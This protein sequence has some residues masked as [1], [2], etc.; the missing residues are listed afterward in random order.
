[1]R[2]SLTFGCFSLN[3]KNLQDISTL[4]EHIEWRKDGRKKERKKQINRN[5][6]RRMNVQD[7]I[8]KCKEKK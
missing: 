7:T 6:N 2:F 4:S 3:N 1:M 5:D 8:K